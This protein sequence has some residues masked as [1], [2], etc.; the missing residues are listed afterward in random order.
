MKDDSSSLELL[1]PK[2]VRI[3]PRTMI[4]IRRIQPQYLGAVYD[5]ITKFSSSSASTGWSRST[6]TN[7]LTYDDDDSRGDGGGGDMTAAAGDAVSLATLSQVYI[8]SNRLSVFE[9]R[10]HDATKGSVIVVM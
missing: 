6:D 10:L 9:R 4:S 2:F 7:V 8:D 5:L 1:P 3:V